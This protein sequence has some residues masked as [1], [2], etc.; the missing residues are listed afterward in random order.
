[1]AIVSFALFGGTALSLWQAIR[2][3]RAGNLAGRKEREAQ[4]SA[5]ES[6][7]ILEFLVHDLLGASEPEKGL[8]R[9]VK[10]AEVLANAE[11]KIVPHSW[12]SPSWKRGFAMHSL[13][14]SVPWV[15]SRSPFATLGELTTC[16]SGFWARN[17]RT[18]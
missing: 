14:P 9:D 13:S 16:A 6:K 4:T 2:A 7:A 11:T 12:T 10:V 5:A 8:G 3:T 1:V 15:S 17:I 18:H